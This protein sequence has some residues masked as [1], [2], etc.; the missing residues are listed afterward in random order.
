MST[1]LLLTKQ[2]NEILKSETFTKPTNLYIALFTT[3]PNASGTGGIEVSTSSSGYA[4][5]AVPRDSANWAGPDSS[6]SYTN[7]NDIVFGTP[8]AN[9]GTV[10][11]VGVFTEQTGGDLLFVNSL[12]TSRTINNGEGAPRFVA[13]NLK[14]SPT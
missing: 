7:I 10:T 1:N 6:L 14:F 2:M 3:A 5:I 12:T 11:A 8:I 4:R 9:W 13:G